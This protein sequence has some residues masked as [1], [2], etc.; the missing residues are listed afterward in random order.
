MLV[1]PFAEVVN[2]TMI[3]TQNQH[4]HGMTLHQIRILLALWQTNSEIR[5]TI[6]DLLFPIVCVMRRITQTVEKRKLY[7]LY[8]LTTRAVSTR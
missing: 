6:R 2:V 5:K 4:R 3:R 7:N 8:T 1:Q